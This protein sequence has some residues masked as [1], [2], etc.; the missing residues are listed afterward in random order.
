MNLPIPPKIDPTKFKEELE[1]VTLVGGPKDG[2]RINVNGEPRELIIEMGG[3]DLSYT[4]F[5]LTDRIFFY[6]YTKLWEQLKE[7]SESY[8]DSA[9]F[10]MQ[11]AMQRLVEWYGRICPMRYG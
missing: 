4:R 1:K 8:P 6:V 10:L 5:Y 3:Q 9:G 7:E 2:A 11:W